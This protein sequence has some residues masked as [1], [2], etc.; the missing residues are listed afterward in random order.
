MFGFL[1]SSTLWFTPAS[2]PPNPAQELLTA[3]LK[4]MGPVT[5]LE[6]CSLKSL[7]ICYLPEQSG[8]FRGAALWNL[9]RRN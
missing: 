6:Q 8:A 5:R 7:E 9:A 1:A 4:A 2:L 3:S